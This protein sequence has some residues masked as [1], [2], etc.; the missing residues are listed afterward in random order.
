MDLYLNSIHNRCKTLLSRGYEIISDVSGGFDTRSLVTGYEHLNYPVRY[1][2]H[3]LI[4]GDE[5]SAVDP[6][7]S[8]FGINIEPIKSSHK[9]DFDEMDRL[10][11]GLPMVHIMGGQL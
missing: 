2:T 3:I 1:F 5:S 8:S 4:T 6:L 7:A 11:S 9:M 10:S